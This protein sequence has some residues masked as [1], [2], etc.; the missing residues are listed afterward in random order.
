ME[1]F[2]PIAPTP[3][4]FFT[5]GAEALATGEGLGATGLGGIAAGGCVV[6]LICGV[7]V[8]VVVCRRQRRRQK[9]K[10]RARTGLDD[11]NVSKRNLIDGGGSGRELRVPHAANS[12]IDSSL[13]WPETHFVA[14][15]MGGRGGGGSGKDCAGCSGGITQPS[16]HT[17]LRAVPESPV[18]GEVDTAASTD[19]D[20]GEEQQQLHR[21]RGVTRFS[22]AGRATRRAETVAFEDSRQTGGNRA[23][24]PPPSDASSSTKAVARARAAKLRCKPPPGTMSAEEADRSSTRELEFPKPLAVPVERHAGAFLTDQNSRRLRR[25]QTGILDA[26]AA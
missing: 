26:H 13:C 1:P 11:G 19:E 25:Q 12:N 15:S 7:C 8:C 20:E 21:L 5:V 9:D 10:G 24:P 4:P 23:P 3:R 6:L 18:P 17:P 16:V 2:P 14:P 22:E